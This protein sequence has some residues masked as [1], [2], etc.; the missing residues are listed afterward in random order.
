MHHNIAHHRIPHPS[1]P[2][3]QALTLIMVPVVCLLTF[4]VFMNVL[5]VVVDSTIA[6]RYEAA[7]SFDLEDDL[8]YCPVLTIDQVNHPHTPPRPNTTVSDILIPYAFAGT[9]I[10]RRCNCKINILPWYS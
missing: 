1:L 8:E 6:A 7:K 5:T 2:R 10:L 4:L 3:H 9:T